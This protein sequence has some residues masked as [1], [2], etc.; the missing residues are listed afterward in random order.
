MIPLLFLFIALPFAEMLILIKM[1][2]TFGFWTTLL[3]ILGTG[4]A[5]AYLA[6]LE[7]LRTW[8]NIQRELAAGR[9]PADQMLDGVV[10]LTAGILLMTPGMLT[11]VS[12]LL[13]L[14][15]WTRQWIKAWLKK[16]FSSR[17]TGATIQNEEERIIEINPEPGEEE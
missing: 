3:F 14:F 7:G 1:G 12:G 8:I 17:I 9:M 11:D 15:P 4:F 16:E 5:G 6:K 10:I 13:L 2:E